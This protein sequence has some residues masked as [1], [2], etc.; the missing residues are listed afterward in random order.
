VPSGVTAIAVLPFLDL[1]GSPDTTYLGL[2]MTDGLI[3][4]LA[5]VGSLKVISRSSGARPKARHDRS[6]I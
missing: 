4:D 1:A 2:G 3:A 6:R 5:E